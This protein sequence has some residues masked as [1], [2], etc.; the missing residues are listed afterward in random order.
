MCPEVYANDGKAY[1]GT[2]VDVWGL[3][4][5]L[6]F[7][8]VRN[9]P[10]WETASAND[11]QFVDFI[12]NQKLGS[13]LLANFNISPALTQLLASMLHADPR[14]R[15]SCQEIL[16]HKWLVSDIWKHPFAG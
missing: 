12:I 6:L 8:L 9:K 16:N 3:G 14:Q 4:V 1:D 5:T 13:F 7:L 10:L 11:A 15:P 2:K